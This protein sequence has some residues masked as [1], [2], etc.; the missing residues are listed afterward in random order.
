MRTQRLKEFEGLNLV[1]VRTKRVGRRSVNFYELSD[2]GKIT[3][4]L[5]EEMKR[6]HEDK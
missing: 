5:A 3:L 1:K 2:T 4:K 6:L